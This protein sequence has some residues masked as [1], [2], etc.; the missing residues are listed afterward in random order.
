ML[1]NDNET[2]AQEAKR[3]RGFIIEFLE[4]HKFKCIPPPLILDLILKNNSNN[5]MY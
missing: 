2:M 3:N 4:N 5:S 1:L